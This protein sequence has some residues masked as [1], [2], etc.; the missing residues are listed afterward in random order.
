[1]AKIR[2]ELFLETNAKYGRG[3]AIDYYGDEVSIMA[4]TRNQSGDIWPEWC[5]PQK[6]ENGAN[7]PS[8]K[9]I[10]FKIRLGVR[11]D[12]IRKL[13]QLLKMLEFSDKPATPAGEPSPYIDPGNDDT[14]IPF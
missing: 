12:A 10:P 9:S 14:D 11:G 8:D 1:M 4:A 5:Y 2:E 6:R 7:V 13:E 3:V